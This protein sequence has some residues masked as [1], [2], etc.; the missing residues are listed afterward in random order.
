MTEYNELLSKLAAQRL[1]LATAKEMKAAM[2][3]TFEETPSFQAVATNIESADNQISELEKE[4]RLKALA[5]FSVNGIKK[6]HP[7]L[8]IRVTAKVVYDHKEA[9]AWAKENLPTAFSFNSQFFEVYVKN[10]A[11]VPCATIEQVPTATIAT[12]LS[13]YLKETK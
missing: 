13:E 11:D 12:D 6:P 8:G 3:K 9:E 4:L 5:D 2:V 10:V 1:T 7:A